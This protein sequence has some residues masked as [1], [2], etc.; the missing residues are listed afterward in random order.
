MYGLSRPREPYVV[1][2]ED[3]YRNYNPVNKNSQSKKYT[4][5]STMPIVINSYNDPVRSALSS[6]GFDF[7]QMGSHF[8][9]QKKMTKAIEFVC[10][11][12]PIDHGFDYTS[13]MN[14]AIF[15]KK[16]RITQSHE[17]EMFWWKRGSKNG[18]EMIAQQSYESTR[19]THFFLDEIDMKKVTTKAGTKKR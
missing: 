15:D 11:R 8:Y 6:F 17:D 12:L 5:R 14:I 18:I 10:R 3:Y 13:Y 19:K 1:I 4:D 2:T 9:V 16:L 7:S